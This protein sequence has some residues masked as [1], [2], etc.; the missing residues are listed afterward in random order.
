M[1][2]RGVHKTP[3]CYLFLKKEQESDKIQVPPQLLLQLIEQKYDAYQREFEICF[4][5]ESCFARVNTCEV[6][7]LFPVQYL[8]G[9][10]LPL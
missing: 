8:Q 6:M 4:P 3:H 5:N 2:Y 1:L 7:F 9:P 10:L